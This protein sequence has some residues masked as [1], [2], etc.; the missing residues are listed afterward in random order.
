[1]SNGSPVISSSIEGTEAKG[2]RSER[3]D[4]VLC[5][6]GRRVLGNRGGEDEKMPV[7]EVGT[8]VGYFAFSLR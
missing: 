1:M 3:V 4:A 7:D 6:P 8:G 5:R 2:A